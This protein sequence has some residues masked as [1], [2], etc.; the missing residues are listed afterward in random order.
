MNRQQMLAGELKDLRR[1]KDA[2]LL[3]EETYANSRTL[4]FRHKDFSAN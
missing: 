4:I 2:G 1:L 3:S